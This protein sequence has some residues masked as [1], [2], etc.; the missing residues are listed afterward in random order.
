MLPSHCNESHIR[1]VLQYQENIDGIIKVYGEIRAHTTNFHQD[2]FPRIVA[3]ASSLYN[4]SQT[5]QVR[6]FNG[7]PGERCDLTFVLFR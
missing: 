2:L 3:L 1:F 5:A 6:F 4:Y 7:S